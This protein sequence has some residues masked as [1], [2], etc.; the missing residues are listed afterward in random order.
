M[1]YFEWTFDAE[2]AGVS[3]V[4]LPRHLSDNQEVDPWVLKMCRPLELSGGILVAADALREAGQD[5]VFGAFDLLFVSRRL[6]DAVYGLVG[7]DVQLLD[8]VIDGVRGEY[9]VV[10]ALR[11]L[12]CVDEARSSFTKWSAGNLQR[13]D[14][15][16]QYSGFHELRISCDR[17]GGI[18]IFR[19]W[20]WHMALIVSERLRDVVQTFSVDGTIFRDVC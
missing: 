8:L 1:K 18:D 6:A 20:G 7:D 12:R 5:A 17:I 19:P 14:K 2:L 16:G 13:P 4:D 11:E 9:C 3:F 10:N 15:A